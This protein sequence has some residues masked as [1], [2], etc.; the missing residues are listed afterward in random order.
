MEILAQALKASVLS[1]GIHADNSHDCAILFPYYPAG[2]SYLN[3][4]K[5]QDESISNALWNLCNRYEYVVSSFNHA[6]TIC[7]K[8][9][10]SLIGHG[11]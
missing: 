6:C 10:V 5:V 4:Q 3:S 2:L 11:A 9:T 8:I 7:E 1:A